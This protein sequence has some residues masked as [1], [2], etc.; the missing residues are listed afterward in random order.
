VS[1]LMLQRV[2]VRMLFDAGF[3]DRV[4]ADP[5]AALR[6]V[7]LTAAERQWVVTPP[8]QAYGTDPYRQSRALSGLLEE[9]PVA[10][11]LA[12]R[13]PQGVARLQRF[14]A[15]AAFHA[16]VQQ[17]GSMAEAFGSYLQSAAFAED[18]TVARMA[19]VEAGG[20]QVR[21]APHSAPAAAGPYA[22]DTRLCIAPWVVL[23]AVPPTTLSRYSQVLQR[24]RRHGPVLLDAVLDTTY[25]LPPGPR[26]QD[27]ASAWILVVRDAA[28]NGFSLEE[29]SPELGAL[30][31]AAHPASSFGALCALAVRLG[32]DLQEAVDILEGL[33]TD[34]L[35]IRVPSM[36]QR[37]AVS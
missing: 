28:G 27:A 6:D 1:A 30:L 36:L 23:L 21:R 2:V 33:V 20:V 19:L 14:F 18:Q 35:L 34:Q 24:L 22:E 16:C 11:A 31:A 17:R 29:A 9:Y 4:Y 26:V 8:P 12:V 13:C 7:P 10:G 15:S 25:R 3:R 5:E 37:K 32:A